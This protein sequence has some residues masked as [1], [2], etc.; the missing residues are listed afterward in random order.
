VKFDAT[1]KRIVFSLLLAALCVTPRAFGGILDSTP[2]LKQFLFKEPDSNFYFGFGVSPLSIMNSRFGFELDVFQLH[3]INSMVDIEL[4]DAA[5]GIGLGNSDLSNSRTFTLRAAPKYRLGKFL[6]I[7]PMVGYE[8]VSFPSVESRIYKNNYFT[9]FEPF[10]GWGFIYGGAA[11]ETFSFGKD[12]IFK[13]N[14]YVYQ[15]TYSTTSAGNGWA[16]N[17]QDSG[18]AASQAPIAPSTVFMIEFSLLY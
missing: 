10:S 7:G 12:Y 15:E 2:D 14:E 1:A 5:F 17:Y 4:F 9:P 11:S 16:Y 18:I 6:S 13:I 3:Y 8:F